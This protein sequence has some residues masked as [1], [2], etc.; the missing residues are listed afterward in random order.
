MNAVSP[1]LCRRVQVYCNR[2]MF[3]GLSMVG[4]ILT[5]LM[6]VNTLITSLGLRGDSSILDA[7]NKTV[8]S[9]RKFNDRDNLHIYL[10]NVKHPDFCFKIFSKYIY[11]LNIVCRIAF[12]S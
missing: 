4:A 7:E 6:W 1:T 3:T 9:E 5:C 11:F 2:S 12:F 8:S 10:Q